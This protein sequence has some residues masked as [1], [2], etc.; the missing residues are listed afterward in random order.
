[1]LIYIATLVG[2]GL[3]MALYMEANHLDQQEVKAYIKRRR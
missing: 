3:I 2:L 1:M